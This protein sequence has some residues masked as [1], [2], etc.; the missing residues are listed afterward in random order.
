MQ[1]YGCKFYEAGE[2]QSWEHPGEPAACLVASEVEDPHAMELITNLH[3]TLSLLNNCP[4]FRSKEQRCSILNAKPAATMED[5][6]EWKQALANTLAYYEIKHEKFDVIGRRFVQGAVTDLEIRRLADQWGLTEP[7]YF[8]SLLTNKLMDEVQALI[9]E[10]QPTP[11]SAS[12]ILTAPPTYYSRQVS[13]AAARD[14]INY[15]CDAGIGFT[16]ATVGADARLIT[17]P[18]AT[19]HALEIYLS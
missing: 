7:K 17:V 15:L 1:C 11:G 8:L 16:V 13:F 4:G 12:S 14:V 6:P 19:K 3:Q 18:I 10:P 5:T 9:Y 2:P